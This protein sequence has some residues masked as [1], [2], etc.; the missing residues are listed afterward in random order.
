MAL[1]AGSRVGPYTIV[2]R[3][4]AGGMGE[5]YKGRDSRLNRN[6]AI[7]VLHASVADNPE[8]LA[9]F[10]RE[11]QL[12]A[13]LNHPHIAQVFGLEEDGTRAL[14]ME[15]VE[16]PTLAQRIEEGVIPLNEALAIAR[17]IAEALEAAHDKGIIHR[18]LKPANIKVR[19]DGTV[20]VLD[21]GLAKT[22]DRPANALGGSAAMSPT[23][24]IGT[25]EA[26]II[27]GTAAYM[28]PEQATGK[29]AD[30]RSDLWAFGVVVLEMLTGRSA[31]SG[32]TV[33]DV[34]AS[35]LKSEPDWSALPPDTPASIRRLLRRCLEKEPRR[36]L[37]S[38][39]D[40]RLEIDDAVT[41]AREEA[42][43]PAAAPRRMAVPVALGLA[44]GAAL[45]GLATWAWMQPDPKPAALVSRFSITPPPGQRLRITPFE[46]T[47][48]LSPDGK[49]LV[50]SSWE[51]DSTARLS[52]TSGTL[53][54]RPLDQL[55]ARPLAPFGR[56]PFFSPDAGWIGFLDDNDFFM[57]K[58]PSSGGS[59][60]NVC[61]FVGG[62][63]GASWAEDNTIVFATGDRGTG[64]LR[65][66]SGGGEP[67][68]LTT[69]QSPEEGDHLFPSVLPGGRGVLFTIA[70][71]GE[72]QGAQVA[73][74]DGRTSRTRTLI[75]GGGQAQYV[76]TGHLV[77]AA[78][79]TLRA[80]RFDLDTL[81]VLGDPI[82][83]VE[84]VVITPTS[85]AAYTLSEQGMLAYVPG[86][87]PAQPTRGIV[88]VDRKGNEQPLKVP[89]R[90]YAA[91][92]LSPD[93]TQIALEIRDQ[94]N[95]IWIW[96]IARETLRKLTDGPA[97]DFSPLWTPDSRQVVYASQ[98]GGPSNLYVQS[99]D[100]RGAPRRLSKSDR[101][102]WANAITSDGGQLVGHEFGAATS[103]DLFVLPLAQALGGINGDPSGGADDG[104]AGNALVREPLAQST[105]QI[106]PNGRYL[107]Y[108][109]NEAGRFQIYV[110]PFPDVTAG[111]WQVSEHGG[112]RPAW[113]ANGRE[114]FYVDG[115]QALVAVRVETAGSFAW[116]NPAKLI[117]NLSDD[118]AVLI[119]PYDVTKDGRFLMLKEDNSRSNTTAAH[120]IVV[121]NW[122]E[123]LKARVPSR[124]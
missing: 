56:S 119:R 52:G 107:A 86:S 103:F 14:V 50:Y 77:Y 17:Q 20:K 67:E 7:K 120:V 15:L 41:G 117:E 19:P 82:P 59:P 105:A 49:W 18:D 83:V 65:V 5:V 57:K 37:E 38:A 24:S 27:L 26:G 99:A 28:S 3:I 1:P 53:M 40:A 79:G 123:E 102:Q 101:Y 47:L 62:P 108:Q 72:P 76:A 71:A 100:G 35:V 46:N 21:F 68:V 121:A 39:S 31:F 61:K 11:A 118:F 63:R 80:V 12:V 22:L 6:V 94:D 9:R 95:D 16:G 104:L 74:L 81:T 89:L 110:R 13:A 23:V 115:A 25:T 42:S 34:L 45:A 29:P 87:A 84:N 90:P 33:S 88:W 69:P 109:S 96:D 36:R 114:L 93:E 116:D 44:T 32:E 58:V 64:L 122:F 97:L 55:D 106:S 85:A 91:A 112:T 124:R 43:D 60:V 92:R 66:S 2:E 75:K 70:E 78:A 51:T 10:G 54:I 48:A 113:G 30:R 73:V 4:G 8:R 111:K 98:R